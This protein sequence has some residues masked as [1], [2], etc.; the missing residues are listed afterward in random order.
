MKKSVKKGR[1]RAVSVDSEEVE[2]ELDLE[3]NESDSEFEDSMETEDVVE[4][5]VIDERPVE[6]EDGP[7]AEPEEP[8]DQEAELEESIDE[9]AEGYDP[10]THPDYDPLPYPNGAWSHRNWFYPRGGMVFWPGRAVRKTKFKV[11]PQRRPARQ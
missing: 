4:E 10:T 3:D 1:K 11:S 2:E 5:E 8:A 7:V 9:D 6:Q